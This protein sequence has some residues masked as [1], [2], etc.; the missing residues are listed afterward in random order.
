MLCL[1]CNEQNI[2]QLTR[3]QKKKWKV[4]ENNH[5]TIMYNWKD[6]TW[7]CAEDKCRTCSGECL[8][9]CCCNITRSDTHAK[10]QYETQSRPSRGE[11]RNL[12][13]HCGYSFAN[14][15]E[16]E[17]SLLGKFFGK[18]FRITRNIERDELPTDRKYIKV[19]GIRL[20]N[21]SF[22]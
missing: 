6:W 13:F 19:S 3:N 9:H 16:A 22:I 18:S 4:V 12:P 17:K 5:I 1:W 15:I 20:L 14:E 10:R 11:K 21:W 2:S 7:K 8:L